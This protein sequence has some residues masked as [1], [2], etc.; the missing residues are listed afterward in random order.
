MGF[1]VCVIVGKKLK[2]GKVEVRDRRTGEKFE[3]E[4]DMALEKVME[5]INN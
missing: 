3:V 4:K 1:P 5:I 2:D